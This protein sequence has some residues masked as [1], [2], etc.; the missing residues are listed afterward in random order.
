LSSIL[1]ALKKL[2]SEQ[3]Q[4]K[5]DK[6][7]PKK[8]DAKKA[9][10]QRA[11]GNW[12][13]NRLVT[14]SLAVIILALGGWLILNNYASLMK[15]FSTSSEHGREESKTASVAARKTVKKLPVP[16]GR[17]KAVQSKMMNRD[18][19]VSKDPIRS[20]HEHSFSAVVEKPDPVFM[21]QEEPGPVKQPEAS[22]K[23][24][25]ES[26]FKLEAI[27]WSNNPK[28]RFAVINGRI[29]KQ[30]NLIEGL[31]VTEIGRDYVTVQSNEVTGK[32]RFTVE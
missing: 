12:L 8:I 29:V 5:E 27:V 14:T 28:S 2:E 19:K 16:A 17:T 24:F 7:L 23:G 10:N 21:E 1:K 3:P 32:L 13:I 26:R 4:R 22:V 25:D 6:Y 9:I 31:S 15:F 30:G 18:Q 11:R 20:Q